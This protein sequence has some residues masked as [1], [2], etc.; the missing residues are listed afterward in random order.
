[1]PGILTGLAALITAVAGAF[2]GGTQLSPRGPQPAVTVTVTVTAPGRTVTASTGAA[3]RGSRSGPTSQN[4]GS[5]QAAGAV[6]LSSLTPL[7]DNE[8]RSG[9]SASEGPQQIGSATYADSVRF[10]CGPQSDPSSLVYDVAG[11]KTF[12][13]TI[14]VP[15]DATN[16]SGNSTAIQFLKDGSSVQ[17]SPGITTALDQPQNVTIPLSGASQLEISC[18]SSSS[19]SDMDIVV[20][21]ATLTT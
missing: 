13:A 14:G 6:H 4:S 9:D 15:S 12:K 18:A 11:Y 20:A 8:N 10:T 16:A 5:V 1:M 19:E 3:H 17:L 7:Q 2:Y 21:N